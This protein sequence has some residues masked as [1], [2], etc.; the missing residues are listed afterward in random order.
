[1]IFNRCIGIFYKDRE[2]RDK[3]FNDIVRVE[4]IDR[5]MKDVL[6]IG[7]NVIYFLPENENSRGRRFDE[8]YIQDGLSDD[9]VQ[10]VIMPMALPHTFPIVI[11]KVEDIK[12]GGRAYHRVLMERF[13]IQREIF[14]DIIVLKYKAETD[15][16]SL[17]AVAC[18]LRDKY[19][20]R[21]VCISDEVEISRESIDKCIKLFE[22]LKNG[23]N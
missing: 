5:K 16:D 10:Q 19:G 14:N 2:W 20:D 21:V 22:E 11:E 3:I 15:I 7:G 13:D 18:W 4:D 23:K 9:F 8:I 6:F 17:F 12:C 1:M